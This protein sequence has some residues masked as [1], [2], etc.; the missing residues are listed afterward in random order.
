MI[1]TGIGSRK[2]PKV[3]LGL[4]FNIGAKMALLGHILRSGG[5]AGADKA[6][7]NGCK[8]ASGTKKIFFASD[9]NNRPDAIDLAL[10]YHG[11]PH[12]CSTYA[13]KL[14]GR[15]S[16]QILG[17]NLDSPSDGVICWTPDGCV[18]HESR[19]IKTGGTGTAIS[20][21]STRQIKIWNLSRP[22]HFDRWVTWLKS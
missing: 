5:A 4:M 12:L 19:T 2:T 15:N 10:S 20:I 11:A 21:A 18:N 9:V 1:Y 17:I 6:F 22:E 7:E 16:F 13:Q 3:T 14:H 8:S